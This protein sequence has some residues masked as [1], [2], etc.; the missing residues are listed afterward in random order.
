MTPNLLIY[1]PLADPTQAYLSLPMLK[2]Y[3]K[4]HQLDATVLDWNIAATHYILERSQIYSLAHRLGK[5]YQE[6]NDKNS[7][8]FLEQLEYQQIFDACD[9]MLDFLCVQVSPKEIFQDPQKFYDYGQYHWAKEMMDDFW[10]ALSA[11]YFPYEYHFNRVQHCVGLWDWPS[12]E[13]Y[14]SQHQSPFHKF[15]LKKIEEFQENVQ[16]IGISLTFV[17]QIPET[18]YLCHLIREKLPHVFLILGGSCLHQI[19]QRLDTDMRK[20]VLQLVDA[21]SLFEG[22]EPL[23]QLLVQLPAWQQTKDPGARFQLL[24]GIPNLMM[25]EPDNKDEGTNKQGKIHLG[26]LYIHD[27]QQSPTPDYSDLGLDQYLAPSRTLLYAPTRGCY[28]NQCSFCEYGF[29]QSGRHQYREIPAEMA[30]QQLSELSQKY[31]VQHFYL[32]CDVLAPTYAL[33][34]AQGIEKQNLPIHWN[35]D[36]RIEKYY[37]PERCKQLYSGGMRAVAFGIES[38]SDRIL[39]LMHKGTTTALVQEINRNFYQAG[40]ATAWMAF[41]Y[42]PLETFPEAVATIEMIKAQDQYISL[43]IVGEFDLT[44]GAHIAC[45]PKEYGITE[46]YYTAGDGFRLYPIFSENTPNS[47]RNFTQE[48]DR[49]LA[50]LAQSYWFSHYPWAGAISTHHSFL[51][52]LR[53]GPAAFV[54]QIA[55]SEADIPHIENIPHIPGF[56]IKPKFSLKQIESKKQSFF[57]DYRK[58]ALAPDQSGMAP[59]SAAHFEA[60][61]AKMPVLEHG[62]GLSKKAK[63]RKKG[64]R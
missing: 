16:F 26:P 5:R 57:A 12:I 59:L 8:S 37:T 7:L 2:A 62:H 50:A 9:V 25:L 4:A 19:M 31:N 10:R 55:E 47:S 13:A 53:Y 14:W 34:L 36:L 32:S 61:C 22:E 40:I 21:V 43:F 23:R 33:E 49:Q 3:L 45:H 64:K 60:C 18:F 42:H 39:Q 44:P 11:A 58:L 38:G 41:H 1:P 27:I 48:L 24:Q 20:Q 56:Q 17:S 46:I 54:R 52:F 63:A 28:W 15:Y 6:L 51:Y 29:G 35:C 30:V